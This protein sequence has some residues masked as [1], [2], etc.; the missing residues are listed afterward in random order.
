MPERPRI[1]IVDDE[2][3]N[4]DLLEQELELLGYATVA[5][6]DGQQALERLAAG[7][8]D[9]VLLD[10][11][12]PDVDGLDVVRTVRQTRSTEEL[13]IIMVSAKSFSEDVTQCLELGANDYVTKP[14]DFEAT[15]KL[16]NRELEGAAKTRPADQAEGA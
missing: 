16:I 9:L 15:L 14:V 8:I 2:P 11:M 5:A 7:P 12:M 10:I 6:A 4:V 3:F 1:L 13:P